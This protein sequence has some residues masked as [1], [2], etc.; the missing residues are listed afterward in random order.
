MKLKSWV[1][2]TLFLIFYTQVAD[3]QSQIM[4]RQYTIN[5]KEPLVF[6]LNEE[7]NLVMLNFDGAVSGREFSTLPYFL[8]RVKVDNFYQDYDYEISAVEYADMTSEEV[9]LIPSSFN[10]TELQPKV[11]TKLEKKRPFAEV[12]IDSGRRIRYANLS[13]KHIDYQAPS[14]SPPLKSWR[15]PCFLLYRILNNTLA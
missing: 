9:G 11:T 14:F 3:C 1:L 13:Q 8:D 2:L 6:A 5:W 12:T 7:E 4:H 10:Y 15:T